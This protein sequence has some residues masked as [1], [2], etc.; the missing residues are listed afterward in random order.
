MWVLFIQKNA[1][2]VQKQNHSTSQS[3]N[4]PTACSK[5]KRASKPAPAPAPSPLP[6]SPKYDVPWGNFLVKMII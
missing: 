2:V 4:L 6:L 1:A 3:V 5:S